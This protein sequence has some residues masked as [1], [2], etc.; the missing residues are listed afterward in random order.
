MEDHKKF[1]INFVFL[2]GAV[3]LV[4]WVHWKEKFRANG[5]YAQNLADITGQPLEYYD[6]GTN[7]R[8]PIID[9]HELFAP[10]MCG[11]GIKFPD[12]PP[13]GMNYNDVSG[14]PAIMFLSGQYVINPCKRD[15]ALSL[16]STYN[17]QNKQS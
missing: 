8:K 3:A 5:N 16:K 17:N 4:A 14:Q 12:I 13:E 11:T 7:G 2:L 6:D 1:N 9:D 10:Y 15:E